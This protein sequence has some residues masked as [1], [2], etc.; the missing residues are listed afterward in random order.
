MTIT[1]G[2]GWVLV[3]T[4]GVS[5]SAIAKPGDA[6]RGTYKASQN[7]ECSQSPFGARL[8]IGADEEP[9]VTRRNAASG[10]ILFSQHAGTGTGLVAERTATLATTLP[11]ITRL[12]T[13]ALDF[14]GDGQK[15][16][17]Y[18]A[19]RAGTGLSSRITVWL[20]RRT[21][22]GNVLEQ[23]PTWEFAPT[24][25]E[26]LL[27]LAIHAGNIDPA[28]GGEEIVVVSRWS[29]S[30]IRVFV[31]SAN[32][33][34]NIA[35]PNGEGLARASYTY[36]A[37]DA[38]NT[39]RAAVG[40]VLLEGRDQIVILTR[41]SSP[42]RW[43]YRLL[44]Y[45]PSGAQDARLAATNFVWEGGV[46]NSNLATLNLLVGDLGGSAASE[47]VIQQQNNDGGLST[48]LLHLHYFTTVRNASNQIT[49]INL[50]RLELAGSINTS[51]A[52]ASLAI[53]ELDRRPPREIVAAWMPSPDS[54]PSRRMRVEGYRVVFNVDG[55]PTAIAPANPTILARIQ[56]NNDFMTAQA[57][58]VGDADGD[59][60]GDVYV[61]AN[62][63]GTSRLH[64]LEM[65]AP[66]GNPNGIVD[67]ATFAVRGTFTFGDGGS[68]SQFGLH[69]ADF[70]RDSVL[71]RLGTTCRRVTEP[72]VRSLVFMPPSWSRLQ[73][74][75]SGF[76]A[77]VGQQG[78]STGTSETRFSRFQSHDVSGYLGVSV[79]GDVLGIGAKATVKATFGY[80][81]Q[82]A[83]GEVRAQSVT[84]TVTEG[85]S[86]STGR[87]LVVIEE[88]Q[89]DCYDYDVIQNGAVVPNSDLRACEHRPAAVSVLGTSLDDW[90][91]F[92][93][94]TTTGAQRAQWTG[95]EPDW[96][97]IALFR[98]VSATAAVSGQPATNAVDGRFDTRYTSISAIAPFI[99]IDL[100]EVRSIAS[101][102]VHKPRS[103]GGGFALFA[104]SQPFSGS[105]LPSGP[106]VL[107]YDPDP[108]TR[109]GVDVW[110][111]RTVGPAP[112][113][114][115]ISAR[116]LRIQNV[117][118]GTS[119]LVLTQVQV[120]DATHRQPPTYPAAVCDD[121]VDDDVFF[122][123]VADTVATTPVYR[124]IQIRGRMKWLGTTQNYASCGP[125]ASSIPRPNIWSTATIG[126]GTGST[127]W[128]LFQGTT[129]LVGTTG[130][131]THSSRVGAEFDVEAGF[132][133]Q[134]VA[135]GAYSFE[136]GVTTENSSTME[137]GTGFNYSGTVP[138]ALPGSNPQCG[139]R[140]HPYAYTRVE[141]SDVGYEHQ[142]TVVDYIVPDV[143]NWSRLGPNF[144]PQDCF[145]PRAEPIFA[146][147][148]EP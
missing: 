58:A 112:A 117:G 30:T 77:M 14:D 57:I 96:A 124:T 7:I 91:T 15:E 48:T 63:G 119:Q 56:M 75:D 2:W 55:F 87:G 18:A 36:S 125:V 148:F 60:I 146:S 12:E 53:G 147:G 49:G 93:S 128:D 111:L 66:A 139:F 19:G 42:P 122:A 5:G 94:V 109:N 86:V 129:N 142:F 65:N 113:F 23:S 40:D 89:F 69:I 84:T 73:P 81:F 99:D 4:L 45:T 108:Q 92:R 11:N 59:G 3:L 144:P 67:T 132:V 54:D 79:G 6:S 137:W 22:P 103:H 17:A 38:D 8:V 97:S 61:V 105:G 136:S 13:A 62:D 106:G 70:D 71:G 9:L 32:A 118:P 25:G 52:I 90:N 68:T 107:R 29:N 43:R 27:D 102:R 20:V 123:R 50:Q 80:N 72:L 1:R 141:R 33:A 21:I 76:E 100:G 35:Q 120:F 116:Y 34:G 10:Q 95:L 126:A 46:G 51:G 110:N 64:R 121:N 138:G 39:L 31:L 44:R 131:L 133:A 115:P 37:S 135:G 104:S 26:T 78:S 145:P 28:V 74:A 134:A 24:T 41:I 47:L 114:V 85:R 130:S 143:P 16:M 82:S 127:F 140:A 88:N 101:V 83:R 98:S